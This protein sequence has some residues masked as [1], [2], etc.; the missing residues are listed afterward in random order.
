MRREPR[1][2]QA[3]WS[4]NDEWMDE[5]GQRNQDDLLLFDPLA[6]EFGRPADHEAR[7]KHRDQAVD[8]PI[9]EADALAAEHALQHHL[10]EH[11]DAG[12]RGIAV[13]RRIHCARR[14]TPL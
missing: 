7:N 11:G 8:Q 2:D 10:P 13:M 1:L 5:Q 14:E 4:E 6:E 3:G 9:E 12:E